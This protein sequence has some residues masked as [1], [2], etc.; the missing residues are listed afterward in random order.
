MFV[1][2]LSNWYIRRSRDRFWGSEMT[3]DKV[4]AYQTLR[5]VLLTLS[6]MI[7]PYAPLIAEDIY[8]NLGGEG[9]VHLA[10]YPR[11]IHSAIDITLEGEMETAR[12][13]VE[14]ARNIRNDTGIKTRQPL[15]ELIVSL[16]SNFDLSRF[17]EIIKDEINIKEIRVEQSD[18][19]FIDFNVKLNLKVAGKK[20]GKFVGPLQNHLKQLSASETKQAVDNGFLEVMIDGEEFHITLDEMLVEKQ[21][22]EGFAS[23]SSNQITVALNT[24]I[25]A[26]LE[27]EGLVRE[28]IRAIQ[29][30][31]KKLELP[32]DKRVDLV[33][34]VNLTFK[35]AL[36]RFDHV[37]Q[38]NV[39]LSSVRYAKEEEMESILIGDN[40]FRLLIE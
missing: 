14:L 13:I 30:Y 37:L 7:A 3:V 18:S 8:S 5:E 10:D 4:S 21:A 22:K 17:E 2:E 38:E 39:L 1:D 11:E 16:D 6:R 40:N 19:G 34:D 25:T 9:S 33:L 29:D 23:A 32:I 28:I 24:S 27:Q 31:R 36:E 20:Y 26:E 15:S 12:Q 35:E